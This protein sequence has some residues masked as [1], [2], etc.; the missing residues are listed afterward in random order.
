MAAQQPEVP[1]SVQ[2][3]YEALGTTASSCIAC[4]QCE[5]VCPQHIDIIKK[6]KEAAAILER[7]L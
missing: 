6:L 5:S 3:H 4:G 7:T 1:E 2:S